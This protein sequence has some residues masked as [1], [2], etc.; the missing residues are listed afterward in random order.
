LYDECK[1]DFRNRGKNKQINKCVRIKAYELLLNTNDAKFFE[2]ICPK[3]GLQYCANDIRFKLADTYFKSE[4]AKCTAVNGFNTEESVRVCKDVLLSKILAFSTQEERLKLLKCIQAAPGTSKEAINKCVSSYLMPED[5]D[6]Q[7]RLR[8]LKD[9]FCPL[10]DFQNDKVKQ[11]KCLEDLLL[12]NLQDLPLSEKCRALQDSTARKKC[13]RME[14]YDRLLKEQNADAYDCW[15]RKKFESMEDRGKCHDLSL[16]NQEKIKKCLQQ[17]DLDTQLACLEKLGANG[18]TFKGHNIADEEAAKAI[19]KLL[20][21]LNIDTSSCKEVSP[22]TS[23]LKKLYDDYKAAQASQN[24]GL[25]TGQAA[26]TNPDG[27]KLPGTGEGKP[28]A[29]PASGGGEGLMA[30]VIG[31]VATK[32]LD[33]AGVKLP[34]VLQAAFSMGLVPLIKG[35]T[36]AIKY[37][38]NKN[39]SCQCLSKVGTI[40]VFDRIRQ[41]F[42]TKKLTKNLDGNK[43]R[44]QAEGVQK[45]ADLEAG[46]AKNFTVSANVTKVKASQN[47]QCKLL[48]T[49]EHQQAITTSQ[50]PPTC[51]NQKV[52]FDDSRPS[53]FVSQ[54]E[55][56]KNAYQ[57]KLIFEEWMS[58]AAGD[59]KSI[60]IDDIDYELLK[61]TQP[62]FEEREPYIATILFTNLLIG[63]AIAEDTED[64]IKA[65]SGNIMNLGMQLLT[66]NGTDQKEVA[67]TINK[68]QGTDPLVESQAVTVETAKEKKEYT[69]LVASLLSRVNALGELKKQMTDEEKK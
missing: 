33:K 65:Q 48:A 35:L 19:E 10:E 25:T 7:D 34:P 21:D 27:T 30:G 61:I 39:A 50:P 52:A 67:T 68:Q 12:E 66:M 11:D 69:Q 14:L 45:M 38:K 62:E 15:N 58:F 24:P 63:E 3:E 16:A 17:P 59:L 6:E 43:V 51:G 49:Q 40:T 56:A 53:L 1:E 54:L 64:K 46:Q 4:V 37:R 41:F 57:A 28:T 20:A 22:K 9:N 55:E 26:V 29:A 44:D 42:A 60:A 2:D 8:Q 47:E 23:C 32:A 5:A 36:R 31:M 13:Q 18:K